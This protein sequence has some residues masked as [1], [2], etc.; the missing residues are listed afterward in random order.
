M[1]RVTSTPT[2][3]GT[4]RLP[5]S[6]LI[7]L[8]AAGV[9]WGTIGPAVDVVHERPS[10]SVLTIGAYR[11]VAA[12]AV[13]ALAAT[14]TRRWAACLTLVREHGWRVALTGS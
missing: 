10:L 13:L 2:D 6:G 1:R 8:G 12:V 5:W 7:F 3:E 4:G 9:V 14:A 11:A